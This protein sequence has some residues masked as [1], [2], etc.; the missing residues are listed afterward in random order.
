MNKPVAIFE[1]L[2]DL[3]YVKARWYALL[4]W[5]IVYLNYSSKNKNKKIS[6]KTKKWAQALN[7]E[8][9]QNW[10]PALANDDYQ[11]YTESLVNCL[12]GDGKLN[13]I[14]SDGFPGIEKIGDRLYLLLYEAVSSDINVLRKLIAYAQGIDS[15]ALANGRIRLFL[16]PSF[17]RRKLME[18]LNLANHL[19]YWWGRFFWLRSI[20]SAIRVSIRETIISLYGTLRRLFYKDIFRVNEWTLEG[21]DPRKFTV[22]YFSYIVLNYAKLYRRDHF[23]D[24]NPQSPFYPSNIL[25]V[26]ISPE[27]LHAV[28]VEFWK[29]RNNPLP[30]ILLPPRKLSEKPLLH[31]PWRITFIT[32]I[33]V[34]FWSKMGILLAAVCELKLK[35]GQFAEYRDSCKWFDS[36]KIALIGYDILFPPTLSIALESLKIRTIAVQERFLTT[37]VKYFALTFDT[38]MVASKACV[39]YLT[40][41][42][43]VQVENLY[44]VGMVRTDLIKNEINKQISKKQI[45]V[46]VLD[47]HSAG[48]GDIES[49]RLSVLNNWASNYQFYEEIAKLCIDYPDIDFILRGKDVTWLELSDFKNIQMKFESLTNLTISRDYSDFGIQYILLE[50]SQIAI[51]RHTSLLDEA[52]AAGKPAIILDYYHGATK[53]TTQLWKYTDASILAHSYSDLKALFE[54]HINNYHQKILDESIRQLRVNWLGPYDGQVHYRINN[55]IKEIYAN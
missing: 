47:Y 17:W 22:I 6:P 19:P 33:K 10:D 1:D 55:I 36:A 20:L 8:H 44:S 40:S 7:F 49:N 37:F 3:R 51:G 50:Q 32:W 4:G 38:Y 31:R 5:S 46:L 53:Y 30:A 26:Y 28:P 11:G 41:V 9:C 24:E 23:Y 52:L 12:N 42:H 43:S 15:Q 14:F 54:K 39:E 34:F 35:Q 25:N 29:D 48:Q 13:T 45:Q 27:K 21:H 18:R 16:K 2:D